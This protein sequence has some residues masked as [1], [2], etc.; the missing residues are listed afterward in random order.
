MK[1]NSP[2]GPILALAIGLAWAF[3]SVHR[4]FDLPDLVGVVAFSTALALLA[5]AAWLIVELAD[6]PRWVMAA[7]AVV[8]VGGLVAA[9]GNFI[10]DGVG[11][12]SFYLMYSLGIFGGLAGLVGLAVT[13]AIERRFRL[14]VV[15]LATA[16]GVLGSEEAGGGLLVLAIWLVVAAGFGAGR[17]SFRS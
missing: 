6:R 17:T 9:I 8:S 1:A 15:S 12:K 7:A 5:P 10:E 2:V 13:L 14:G 11:I 16:A 4:F 3:I